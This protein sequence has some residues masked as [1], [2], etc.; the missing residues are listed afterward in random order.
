MGGGDRESNHWRT[1]PNE[2]VGKSGEDSHW[3]WALAGASVEK[4]VVWL[5]SLAS[6]TKCFEFGQ[7]WSSTP[8]G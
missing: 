1:S 2:M 8:L 5:A 3:D 6:L 7:L 4:Q